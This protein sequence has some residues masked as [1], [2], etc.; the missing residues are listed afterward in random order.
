MIYRKKIAKY[1]IK[2]HRYD[3]YHSIVKIMQDG[4]YY[5]IVLEKSILIVGGVR[6]VQENIN[7]EC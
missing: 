5:M 7:I 4:I 6:Y 1:T 3:F 2:V